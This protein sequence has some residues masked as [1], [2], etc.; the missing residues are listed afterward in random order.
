MTIHNA[1]AVTTSA[2]FGKV[3]IHI[4]KVTGELVTIDLY[5]SVT[6]E[7]D[8]RD[9]TNELFHQLRHCVRNNAAFDFL[10]LEHVPTSFSIHGVTYGRAPKDEDDGTITLKLDT[11]NKRTETIKIY[12]RRS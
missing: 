8:E 3:R 5:P 4:Q 11:G 12:P 1:S 7:E 2:K 6:S 10:K 9:R